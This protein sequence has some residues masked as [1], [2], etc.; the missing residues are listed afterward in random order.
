[1][2]SKVPTSPSQPGSLHMPAGLEEL[3]LLISLSV[4]YL[5]DNIL[6]DTT[7]LLT[8]KGLP[9]VVQRGCGFERDMKCGLKH[10]RESMWSAIPLYLACQHSKTLHFV[11][12][13]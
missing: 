1:M 13:I 12:Y 6:A 3:Q 11:K 10:S 8:S 5:P 2:W 7:A 4:L 9:A